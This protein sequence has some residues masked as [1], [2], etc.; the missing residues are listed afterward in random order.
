M[1]IAVAQETCDPATG[2]MS[3]SGTTFAASAIT[4]SA[5]SILVAIVTGVNATSLAS[6]SDS[7]NGTS[8]WVIAKQVTN[9]PLTLAIA[10]RENM[11]AGA[12]TVTATYAATASL[13]GIKL[14]EITGAKT[15]SAQDGTPAGQ[16]QL[17][18]G[19]GADAITSGNTTNANQPALLVGA[20]QNYGN[21]KNPAAGGGFTSTRVD[22]N[23]DVGGCRVEYKTLTTTTAV[24]ATY[25]GPSTDSWIT[26]AAAFDEAAGGAGNTMTVA[27]TVPAP[28]S[29][30]TLTSTN[31]LSVAANAGTPTSAATVTSTNSLAIA[32]S[33]PAPAMAATMAADLVMTVAA[34][35]PAPTAAAV[36]A[37]TNVLTIATSV[38]APGALAAMESANG[39]AVAASVPA[40]TSTATLTSTNA[41]AV[42]GLAPSPAMAATMAADLVM[43]IAGGTGVP[44]CLATLTIPFVAPPDVSPWARIMKPR[45]ARWDRRRRL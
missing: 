43:V 37:S 32:A 28:T 25:T 16:F 44:T 41:L 38:P 1:A 4:L 12:V 19:T 30:A 2:G 40:P 8:G 11:A 21:N 26:L 36:L 14:L 24:A 9:A 6:I 34:P 7:V 33:V 13:R 27:A 29:S 45:Y 15:S 10:Y 5:G 42:A 18:V 22:W 23:T 17:N 35:I 31:A 3:G 39:I 20:C